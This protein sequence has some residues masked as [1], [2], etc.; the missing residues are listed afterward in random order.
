MIKRVDG[1]SNSPQTPSPIQKAAKMG[2]TAGETKVIVSHALASQAARET[3]FKP[4]HY[5]AVSLISKTDGNVQAVSG[6][7]S[8]VA[9][10]TIKLLEEDF[11][12]RNVNF[13]AGKRTK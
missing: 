6:L 7:A 9:I 12:Q 5:V 8:T 13:P 2:E 3:T 10:K 4:S 11:N 1:S